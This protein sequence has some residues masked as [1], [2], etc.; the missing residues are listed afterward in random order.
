VEPG[1]KIPAHVQ[2]GDA[3][4]RDDLIAQKQ[5]LALLARLDVDATVVSDMQGAPGERAVHC[6]VQDALEAYLPLAGMVDFAKEKKRLEKQA[7]KMRKDMAGLESRLNSPGFTDKA[8]A[9]V[10]EEA[11]SQLAEQQDRLATILAS[12]DDLQ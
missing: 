2:V 3:A 9:H 7:E 6:V 1:R 12:I 4:L 8:P 11:R 5:V 10:V